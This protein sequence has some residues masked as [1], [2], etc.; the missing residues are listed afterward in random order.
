MST[1]TKLKLLEPVEFGSEH[2]LELE[3]KKPT[4]GDIKGMKLTDPS[5]EDILKI[6]SK[7]SGQSMQIIDRLSIADG[8]AVA[9]IVGN[10]LSPSPPTAS[11]PSQL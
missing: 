10:F 6:A 2:I 11:Q 5:L 9:E 1:K 3:F 4:I 7:L 8:L